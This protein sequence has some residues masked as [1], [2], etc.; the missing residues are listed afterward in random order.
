LCDNA[1]VQN[2]IR[3]L[4]D[5]LIDYAGLFPPAGLSMALAV[6]NYASY[7]QSPDAFALGR[8]IVPAT[9]LDELLRATSA[10][11]G[12][13]PLSVLIGAS[14]EDDFDRLSDFVFAHGDVASVDS[15]EV[16]AATA[17][18]VE[19]IARRTSEHP[20]A[21][22]FVEIA[23]DA[24][25]LLDELARQRLHAKIRTGGVTQDAFP[26]AE[27]IAGFI[28]ACAARGVAFK[29][30]AGL[31]HPLR[32]VRP[33]TYEADAPSGTMH[34]FV[35]VFLAGALALGGAP[36]ARQL[37]DLLTE[38]DPANLVIIENGILW[39][40]EFL[41]ADLLQTTRKTLALSFGSC[42][43]EEPLADLR[44]LGWL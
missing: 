22:V 30:T 18:D 25:T 28:E 24:T 14:T 19:R 31:H 4:L 6:A 44:E 9:R 26:S 2:P 5:R 17:A 10:L 36:S 34:G 7:R 29:A 35:N 41:S 23:P 1:G 39:R 20:A 37:L 33:L 27:A 43:F 3:A 8:F 13:G 40:D 21:E 38:S 32:C 12:P 42:S 16:K 11:S 15:I